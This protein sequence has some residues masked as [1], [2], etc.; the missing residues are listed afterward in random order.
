M[1]FKLTR[2]KVTNNNSSRSPHR[3][4][5]H[6]YDQ[7]RGHYSIFLL[8]IWEMTMTRSTN[9]INCDGNHG[10]ENDND[11]DG[12]HDDN[13]DDNYDDNYEDNLMII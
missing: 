11:D 6:Q 9:M 2:L 3:D 1:A 5:K 7:S 10:D 4:Q 8:S 13:H 12:D